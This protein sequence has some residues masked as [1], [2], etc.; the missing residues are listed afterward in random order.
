MIERLYQRFKFAVIAG[1]PQDASWT[2][3]RASILDWVRAHGAE[4]ER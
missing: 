4:V 1:L 3:T 2:L